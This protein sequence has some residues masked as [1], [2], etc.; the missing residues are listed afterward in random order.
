MAVCLKHGKSANAFLPHTFMQV[1]SLLNELSDYRPLPA[2]TTR[3]HTA[4]TASSLGGIS[5]SN[6]LRSSHNVTPTKPLLT[7]VSRHSSRSN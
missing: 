2:P 5:G 4:G 7:K 6:A 1:R 3:P